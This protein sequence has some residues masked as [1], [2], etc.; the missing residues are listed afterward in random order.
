MAAKFVLS[1]DWDFFV[2]DSS[3]DPCKVCLWNCDGPEK[4]DPTIR[5]R[6]TY[7]DDYFDMDLVHDPMSHHVMAQFYWESWKKT[8][9]IVADCHASIYRLLEPHSYIYNIDHHMDSD[10][11]LWDIPYQ[12]LTCGSWGTLA[13]A[14]KSCHYEWCHGIALERKEGGKLVTIEC[15]YRWHKPE[16]IF[17]CLSSPYTNPQYDKYFY[18]LVE[19]LAKQQET[20]PRFVGLGARKLRGEFKKYAGTR[21]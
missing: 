9:I 12:R 6:Q 4:P 19:Q 1:I 8:P 20:E 10:A 13:S 17:L 7:Q 11:V 21:S 14:N 2:G 5:T 18:Y 16:F 15:N 3:L